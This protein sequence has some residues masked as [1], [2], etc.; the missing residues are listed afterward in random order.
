MGAAPAVRVVDDP[1]A[2]PTTVKDAA[3]AVGVT[4]KTVWGWV[5]SWRVPVVAVHNP[6][7]GEGGRRYRILVD[8]RAVAACAKLLRAGVGRRAK[9][10]ARRRNT[11]AAW[12]RPRKAEKL[13]PERMA[14][15]E[16]IGAPPVLYG[17]LTEFDRQELTRRQVIRD[18]RRAFPCS[19][20]A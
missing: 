7:P 9:K 20:A 12:C 18:T 10:A 6:A 14:D 15:R 1:T 5:K 2:V 4:E 16:V 19:A 11:P 8:A 3:K 13:P 17:L